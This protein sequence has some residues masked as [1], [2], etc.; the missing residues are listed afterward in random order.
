MR[1]NTYR[2][3]G[4]C[5]RSKGDAIFRQRRTCRL[6]APICHDFACLCPAPFFSEEHVVEPGATLVLRYC[7]V[8]ADGESDPERAARLA[9]AAAA[10]SPGLLGAP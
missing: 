2:N 10:R 3:A 8:I 9:D 1:P 7:V 6:P 4:A 5:W